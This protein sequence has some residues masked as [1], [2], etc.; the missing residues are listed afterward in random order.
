MSARHAPLA[1]RVPSALDRRNVLRR[2]VPAGPPRSHGLDA[3]APPPG[4]ALV[5]AAAPCHAAPHVE[6]IAHVVALFAVTLA[7][8]VACRRHARRP[9]PRR[10][11]G[12]VLVA[13]VVTLGITAAAIHGCALGQ[14]LQQ[15]LVPGL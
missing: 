15:A 11:V 8:V 10:A 14:P 6:A 7:T 3:R 2:G 9:T 13:S 5:G 1:P 12:A 4:G